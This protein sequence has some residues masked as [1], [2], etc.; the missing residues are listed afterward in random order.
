VQTIILT[1]SALVSIS[2]KRCVL[3]QATLSTLQSHRTDEFSDRQAILNST[4]RKL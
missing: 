2:T 3:S 1:I 4:T